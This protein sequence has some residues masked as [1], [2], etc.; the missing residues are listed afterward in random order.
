VISISVVG[1]PG[2]GSLSV[3]QTLETA[4]FI[5]L[6]TNRLA[7]TDDTLPNLGGS[8]QGWWADA[9]ADQEGTHIGSRLWLL[10]RSTNTGEIVNDARTY[11][12]E[13]LQ[14]LVDD[15]IADRVDCNVE[16]KNYS[17]GALLLA[18][19]PLVYKLGQ[20]TPYT[21]LWQMTITAP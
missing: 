17:A 14:W 19:Q 13:A 9:Y 15:G 6:F 20:A 5:S 18:I 8:R 21:S 2:L 1:G 12:R 10:G 3:D 16:V 7:A 4:V 11:V